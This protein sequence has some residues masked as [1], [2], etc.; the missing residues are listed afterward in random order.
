VW[1]ADE[2]A[3]K[4]GSKEQVC[5]LLD[6]IDVKT[7]FLLASRLSQYRRVE[8]IEEVLKEA[9]NR[10]GRLPKVIMT[11]QLR[12]Y[13]YAIPNVFG[14]K[15][16]HL[17]VQKF[18]ARPNNNIIERMQGTIKSRL[19]VM[20]GLKSLDTARMVIDGFLINYNYY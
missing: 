8:D 5:W 19:K 14:E 12:A 7:R 10:S 4:I 15:S 2:T 13:N 3:I 9:Y 18:T 6:I 17:Q 20:R 11:D 1:L 16:R